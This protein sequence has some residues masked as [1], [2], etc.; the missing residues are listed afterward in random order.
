[1]VGIHL[2]LFG[3]DGNLFDDT[4]ARRVH[5]LLDGGLLG[6]T[7][8]IGEYTGWQQDVGPAY[9]SLVAGLGANVREFF[10][11]GRNI[12][13]RLSAGGRLQYC[14]NGHWADV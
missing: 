8:I 9:A 1:M 5:E 6:Q 12:G 3:R 13:G 2:V 4:G 7:F 14:I 10:A 11:R